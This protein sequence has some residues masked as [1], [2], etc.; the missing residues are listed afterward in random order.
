MAIP[1]NLIETDDGYEVQIG[2]AGLESDKIEIQVA[3]SN[4][5]IRGVYETPDTE[6][7]NY[8]WQGLPTGEFSHT[9]NLPTEVT[10]DGAEATYT[11]GLLTV[12][13]P[14]AHYSKMKSIPVKTTH[15]KTA[16]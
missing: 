15:A 5:R 10:G 12:K 16:V 4:L 7:R 13:V 8:V 11:D 2:L 6:A 1:A 14:K 3:E 9:F